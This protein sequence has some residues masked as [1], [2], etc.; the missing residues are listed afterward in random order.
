MTTTSPPIGW[1]YRLTVPWFWLIVALI[2]WRHPGDEYALFGVANGLPSAW[3][4]VWFGMSGEPDHVI[5]V[6]MTCSLISVL[7]VAWVMDRLRVPTWLILV[8][9]LA[10]SVVL[11]Q[12]AYGS[13]ESH[14]RA[15]AKNGSLTAYVAASSNLGLFLACVGAIVVVGSYRAG[16]RL[17][18]ARS[19]SDG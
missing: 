15:I 16:R 12:M 10:G 4:S 13:Y 19:A 7:V 9:W 3:I 14:A 17:F 18:T 1:W 11:F 2:S 8:L 6:M 5:P